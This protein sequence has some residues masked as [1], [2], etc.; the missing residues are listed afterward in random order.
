ML[1]IISNAE[2]YLGGGDWVMAPSLAKK[3]LFDIV[4]KLENLVWYPLCEH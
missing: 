2:A 4:K 3:N 1:M